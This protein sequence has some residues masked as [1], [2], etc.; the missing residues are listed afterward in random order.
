MFPKNLFRLALAGLACLSVPVIVS[1]DQTDPDE[2]IVVTAS[3]SEQSLSASLA[4]VTVIDRDQIEISQA[5]DLLE[6][7]RKQAGVDMARTGGPGGQTSVFL[8]GSNSNH[9]LVL[10][11]GVRVS[12]AGTGA[13]SWELLDPN[14]IERIEIVRGPRAARWGSDAIGGVIQIFTRQARGQ[15]VRA[16]YGRYRDRSIAATMG[17]GQAG[18]TVA[19]RRVG[20]YSS[21]NER[22]FAFDP[23]DDGF[24]NI[25]AATSG[26]TA[27]GAGSLHWSA[28][29]ATGETE[30]DQGES[31]FLN[32]AARVEYQ[33]DGKGPWQWLTSASLYRDRLETTT[34]FGESEVITRRVQ[35]AFQG[36]RIIHED[37]RWMVGVDAW[38]ESGVSRSSWSE[39]RYNVGIW[40]GYDGRIGMLE[41]E[42]AIRLDRDE[43]FGNAVSGNLAAGWSLAEDWR[44]MGSIGRAFRAPNFDQLFSPGFNGQ[45]AG[46]PDL[47]PETSWSTEL[48]LQWQPHTRQRLTLAAFEN[49]IDDLIDFSGPDFQAINIRKARIRGAELAWEYTDSDWRSRAQISWQDSK[50][51][52]TRQRLLRRAR[53]NASVSLDRVFGGSWIGGEVVHVGDR[54]DVGD[55]PLPSHTLVSLRAGYS[56]PAGFRLEGRVENLTDREYEQVFGF[57]THRRS[58]FVAVSW[59]G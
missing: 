13:F 46:N 24:E 8:R 10:I 37:N 47:D 21:Q 57:N 42:S 43:L 23:D 50:D 55:Q 3:R 36:Q 5:P 32:Y 56:L 29:L 19:G 27:A 45:F 39:Q 17:T 54:L 38:R 25:S 12:A 14:L 49:R 2:V 11:D 44:L 20:G 15:G 26:S 58:L 33:S 28:R 6:L 48:G 41:H 34:P 31:D 1:A 18:V 59:E 16:A 22:G 52:D 4:S 7:L 51:R 35:T 40:T 30:F 53:E 9:V